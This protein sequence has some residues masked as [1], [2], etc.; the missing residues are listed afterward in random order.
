MTS[1]AATGRL[2]EPVN[3][4]CSGALQDRLTSTQLQLHSLMLPARYYIGYRHIGS[5]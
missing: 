3:F 5:A 1:S 4:H 2:I